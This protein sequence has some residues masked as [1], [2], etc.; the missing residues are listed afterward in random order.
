MKD[1]TEETKGLS[2]EN[3][4]QASEGETQGTSTDKAKTYTKEE[5]DK[6]VSDALSAAGRDHKTLETRKADL[7]AQHEIV[8]AGLAKIEEWERQQDAEELAEAHKDPV[9]MRA[10]QAKQVDKQR[11]K[12]LEE[13]ESAVAKRE[14]EQDRREAEHAGKVRAAEEVTLGM[15][16]YEIAA[17]YELNPEDLKKDMKDLN[18]TT[19]A[20]VEALA[21]RLKPTGERLPGGE[22]EGEG[23]SIT[24][25]SVPTTGGRRTPTA[26]ELDAMTP[27]Q[28]AAWRKGTK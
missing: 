26:K 13:R 7:D 8:K 1:G 3:A 27:E 22:G 15:K 23:K 24:P 12:S 11:G 19:E 21:K 25:V 18:L 20:Q 14:Q 4:G 6:A 17:K 9:K 16:L 2:S 10:Y 28:Y 5:V